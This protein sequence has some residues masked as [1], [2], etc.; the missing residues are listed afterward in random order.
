[1]AQRVVAAVRWELRRGD[2]ESVV[3]DLLDGEPAPPLA[4]DLVGDLDEGQPFVPDRQ[5][6]AV[7]GAEADVDRSDLAS[8]ERL[9]ADRSAVEQGAGEVGVQPLDEPVEVARIR[10]GVRPPA[11]V[12]R[13]V[14]PGQSGVVGGEFGDSPVC[15]LEVG[16]FVEVGA[17]PQTGRYVELE[18]GGVSVV[19][20]GALDRGA[21]ERDRLGDERRFDAA[22]VVDE[23]VEVGD[24]FVE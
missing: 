8:G 12:D 10:S 7:G 1:M 20:V 2:H 13:V 14:E 11:G 22:D 6:L 17:G 15:G 24:Q 21:S 23:E 18:D 16:R 4:V 19:D 9:S 5:Q 3:G